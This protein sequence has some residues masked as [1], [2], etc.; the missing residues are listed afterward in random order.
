MAGP[1]P[2]G[3]GN[4][5][6]HQ[7]SEG[8]GSAKGNIG[9]IGMGKIGGGSVKGKGDVG[10][11]TAKGAKGSK[12][13]KSNHKTAGKGP[14]GPEG[15]A[16]GRVEGEVEQ[17]KPG[18]DQDPQPG[19]EG[20]GAGAGKGRAPCKAASPVAPA[21][22]TAAGAAAA[23]ENDDEGDSDEEPPEA[24]LHTSMASRS[25]APPTRTGSEVSQAETLPATSNR[26]LSPSP[27]TAQTLPPT[28]T[29][30]RAISPAP[31]T[32]HESSKKSKTDQWWSGR[33]GHFC[34]ALSSDVLG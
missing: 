15:E 16:A 32:A 21:E 12:G 9:K 3:E 4:E 23:R 19:H 10:E 33:L 1:D 8:V 34:L 13:A 7:R 24:L 22:P 11:G 29:S 25:P 5:E 17:S 26:A 2:V 18:G 14:R 28:P 6:G 27:S 30:K 20:K 31:S